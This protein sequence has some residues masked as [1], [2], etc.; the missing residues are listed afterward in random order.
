MS[1]RALVLVLLLS[2]CARAP[3]PGP[4][5][6]DWPTPPPDATRARVLH[7][8]DGDTV[9]LSGLSVGRVHRRTGGRSVRLIGV[10][11]PERD[12]CYGL[13]ATGFTGARLSGRR[14]RVGFD[15]QPTD[16]YGRAL[17]YLWT[18]DGRLFN[19]DLVAEGYAV[20]LTI[21]PNVAH[22]DLFARLSREARGADRG[23]WRACGNG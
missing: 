10:D 7:V 3:A 2:S 15:V 1:L 13:R 11:T 18:E 6:D 23:L 8:T 20:P 9:V 16:R 4:P 5:P 12:D 14:V 22:A 17:V 19:A 21:P